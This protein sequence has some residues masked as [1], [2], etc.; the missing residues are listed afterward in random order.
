MCSRIVN[1]SNST[2][3]IAAHQTI[4]CQ[5][6]V[7]A[8]CLVLSLVLLARSFPPHYRKNFRRWFPLLFLGTVDDN[9]IE[10]SNCVQLT[11]NGPS[12]GIEDR[13]VQ[14]EIRFS[15]QGAR[16]V[17]FRGHILHVSTM[18]RNSYRI[19]GW[20]SGWNLA[21]NSDDSKRCLYSLLQPPS[22]RPS[23]CSNGQKLGRI[24]YHHTF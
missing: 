4:S 9:E 19:L 16:D 18:A 24:I 15:E 21:H 22:R 17:R 2:R 3:C 7:P 20:S 12:T 8:C 23:S 6:A 13:Q 10:S 14:F 1:R 5:C 11:K